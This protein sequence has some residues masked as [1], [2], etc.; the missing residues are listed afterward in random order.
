[1]GL[2]LAQQ[3][4]RGYLRSMSAELVPD[5]EH[6]GIV[7]ALPARLRDYALLARF[8]RPIG[9]WLLF[10]PCAWGLLLAGGEGRWD[11][12]GWFLIGAVA[13]SGGVASALDVAPFHDPRFLACCPW[14]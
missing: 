4:P 14:G 5:S 3:W 8:D 7:A 11:L 9:W 6:R 2:A 1:M 10:W 13:V 12:L